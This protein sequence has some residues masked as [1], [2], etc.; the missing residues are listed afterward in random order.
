MARALTGPTSERRST[1]CWA[2]EESGLMRA[3]CST[4]RRGR[5]RETWALIQRL[6]LGPRRGSDLGDRG[7][8]ALDVGEPRGGVLHVAA[9]AGGVPRDVHAGEASV[10]G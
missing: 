1:A 2:K 9:G 3:R 8:E 5:A 6:R 4:A 7:A 10:A